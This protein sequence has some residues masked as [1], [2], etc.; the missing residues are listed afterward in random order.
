MS[1]NNKYSFLLDMTNRIEIYEA[2]IEKQ[3]EEEGDKVPISE[4]DKDFKFSVWDAHRVLAFKLI[5]GNDYEKELKFKLNQLPIIQKWQK[6][7]TNFTSDM[8]QR[9]GFVIIDLDDPRDERSSIDFMHRTY[10]EYFVAKYLIDFMFDENGRSNDEKDKL[11]FKLLA[12]VI[13]RPK[14]FK[15]VR[16]FFISYINCQRS[17]KAAGSTFKTLILEHVKKTLNLKRPRFYER[18]KATIENYV[19]ISV[20]EPEILNKLWKVDEHENIL[21]FIVFDKY[22]DHS[23]IIKLAYLSFGPNW[24]EKFNKSAENLIKDEKIEELREP[25][26]EDSQWIEDKNFLKFY[27]FVDKNFNIDE[28][29][30]LYGRCQ[31]SNFGYSSN[32]QIQIITRMRSVLRNQE[33]I[34]KFLTNDFYKHRHVSAVPVE[35]ILDCIMEDNNSD[36]ELMRTFLCKRCPGWKSPLVLGFQS[37]NSEILY[38]FKN[39]YLKYKISWEDVQNHLMDIKFSYFLYPAESSIYSEYKNVIAEIFG[40]NISKLADKIEKEILSPCAWLSFK[41]SDKFY[42]NMKDFFLFIFSNHQERGLNLFE[43]IEFVR[44]L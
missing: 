39:L 29:K 34:D 40:E 23:D 31:T 41:Y 37:E 22:T 16:N 21:K 11:K 1:F 36:R 3:K 20:L 18:F 43:K 27:D 2:M 28:K 19:E 5:F 14:K 10:A 4:R 26:V 17:Q 9:Y 8:I 42:A 33:F 38:L 24:H 13:E 35:F 32:I 15:I 6:E 44:H 25:N 12:V 30:K 7:K